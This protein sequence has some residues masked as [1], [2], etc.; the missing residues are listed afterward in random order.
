ML[1]DYNNVEHVYLVCGYTDLRKG[2]DGLAAIIEHEFSMNLFD[3]A[4]FLFCG[5]RPDRFKALY[6]DGEGFIL[7]YKRYDQGKLLWPRKENEIKQLTKK[8][9]QWFFDGLSITPK[10]RVQPA[11]I[12]SLT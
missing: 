4:I 7:L 2:I 3:D 5:K 6:F 8:Q 11:K 1:I 10:Q 9:I 12:G